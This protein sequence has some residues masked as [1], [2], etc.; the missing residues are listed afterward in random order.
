[1]VSSFHEIKHQVCSEFQ[2]TAEMFDSPSRALVLAAARRIA[3]WRARETLN[4]SLGQMGLWTGGRDAST[5]WYGLHL[6]DHIYRG[7]KSPEAAR[8]NDRAKAFY[9]HQ[10]LGPGGRANTLL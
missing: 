10:K 1:V 5:V 6:Q 8:K 7:I 9:Q 3:W 2:I 4:I